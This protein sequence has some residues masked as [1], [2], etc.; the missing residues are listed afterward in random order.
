VRISRDGD[1]DLRHPFARTK[2]DERD[3]SLRNASIR[4]FFFLEFSVESSRR[5]DHVPP[6]RTFEGSVTKGTS[7]SFEERKR[8]QKE[9]RG[10][11]TNE[12]QMRISSSS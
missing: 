11:G 5:L 10:S 12:T 8:I 9:T 6:L 4:E 1:I 7:T 3:T 2:I